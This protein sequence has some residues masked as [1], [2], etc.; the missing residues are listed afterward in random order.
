MRA[1]SGSA[2]MQISR[3]LIFDI[4][5]SEGDDCD[6]YLKKGFRVL[7]LEANPETYA[8]IGAR[9]ASEIEAGRLRVMNLAAS[10]NSGE[11]MIFMISGNQGHSH[12]AQYPRGDDI[13]ARQVRVETI[14]WSGLISIWGTPYYCKIDIEGAEV[15]FLRSLVGQPLPEYISTECHG[16]E[17]IELLYQ[18]GY[19]QF[20]ILHQGSHN[21]FP[22][23]DPP[24]EGKLL[25]GYVF[26]HSS[27]YF[28]RELYGD[29]WFNFK[30]IATIYH[31]IEWA[32]GANT[33]PHIW[34]DCH[35]YRPQ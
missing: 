32:R 25:N 9:F 11:Q 31:A 1:G 5:M 17:P 7:G 29:R 10:E 14:N 35:A 2:T 13:T 6:F 33:I 24:L 22:A 16:F 20:R 28:G 4:G 30:D 3:D 34:F 12:L 18:I 23:P 26:K 27:G 8:H 21:A 15:P 19:R